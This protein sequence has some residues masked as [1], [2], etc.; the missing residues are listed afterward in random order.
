MQ[1]VHDVDLLL[2]ELLL[3][4]AGDGYEL[5]GEHVAGGALA[6]SVDYAERACAYKRIELEGG[7]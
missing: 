4:G 5:G 3:H 1:L 6:A 7:R 2:D